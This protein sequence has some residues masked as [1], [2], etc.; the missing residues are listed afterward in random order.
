LK[1][2]EE[3]IGAKAGDRTKGDNI[4]IIFRKVLYVC[5]HVCRQIYALFVQ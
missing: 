4:L 1:K 3:N 5:T 2:E